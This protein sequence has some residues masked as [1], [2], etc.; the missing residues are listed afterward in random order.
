MNISQVLA[1]VSGVSAV[2]STAVAGASLG[3]SF[4]S[5]KVHRENVNKFRSIIQKVC[6]VLNSNE[7][8]FSDLSQLPSVVWFRKTEFLAKPF[9]YSY[10][11]PNSYDE[12]GFTR[13]DIQ[14]MCTNLDEHIKKIQNQ[15]FKNSEL[16]SLISRMD[17]KVLELILWGVLDGSCLY[18]DILKEIKVS[19]PDLYAKAVSIQDPNFR[20]DE[21]ICRFV[22]KSANYEQKKQKFRSDLERQINGFLG[23]QT[24]SLET[25]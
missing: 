18:L 23:A 25:K 14:L 5:S 10:E 1:A 20:I 6:S 24:E 11:H 22:E 12:A 8:I 17:N 7:E 9:D 13:E 4:D 21:N 3:G 19:N 2:T 15:V 16:A